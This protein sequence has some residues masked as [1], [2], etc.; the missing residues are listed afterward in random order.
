MSSRAKMKT[1]AV[2]AT[3]MPISL[4]PSVCSLELAVLADFISVSIFKSDLST[5]VVVVVA[6]KTGVSAAMDSAAG[7]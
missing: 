7:M 1:P 5:V 4:L 2:H 6:S 3:I